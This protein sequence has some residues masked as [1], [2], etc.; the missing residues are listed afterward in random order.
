MQNNQQESFQRLLSQVEFEDLKKF[1]I[2][3]SNKNVDFGREFLSLF[4]EDEFLLHYE[5][6]QARLQSIIK[7]YSFSGFI[8]DDQGH[9]LACELD[10]LLFEIENL[11]NNNR[12]NLARVFCQCFIEQVIE[13]ITYS[14]DSSAVLDNVLEEAICSLQL[15]IVSNKWDRE[16]LQE[17]LFFYEKQL[18]KDV[19]YQF[20]DYSFLLFDC[21]HWICLEYKFKQRFSSYL[22]DVTSAKEINPYVYESLKQ[23]KE[24]LHL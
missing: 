2:Y 18:R 1:L 12:V 14:D 6:F 13:V 22:E 8:D 11:K 21:Y 20:G 16:S 23:L 3:Y 4:Q 9:D 19:F 10:D 7:K 15:I 5:Q 24:R 17:I